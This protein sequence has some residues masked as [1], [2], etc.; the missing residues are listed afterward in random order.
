MRGDFSVFR[1]GLLEW[2]NREKRPLPWRTRPSLYGTVVSEFMLQ[3]TQ[4]ETVLPYYA[5]WLVTFPDFESLAKA[6]ETEVVKNW[7]GLGYYTRARNLHKLAKSICESGTPQSFD[8]WLNRPGIGPYSA[9]AISS[10]SQN[11]AE[12]VIDGNVIRVLCRIN[13]DDLPIRSST[14][15]RKRLLPLARD[16]IDPDHPG[17]FNE[18]IME[19]GATICRKSR[20]SCL[21]CP[22]REHCRASA[23]GNESSVPV[24]VRRATKRVSNSRLWLVRDDQLLLHFYPANAPRLA[25]LAELPEIDAAKGIAPVLKRTRGISTELITESI[26]QLDLNH[27]ESIRCQ[28]LG[29]SKW[30]PI[31]SLSSISLSGPHRRWIEALLRENLDSDIKPAGD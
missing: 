17:D 26:F 6:E 12:P 15:G 5:N 21:L 13:N 18:A 3:Q 24:I 8:E 4:V 16:L 20:P 14:D 31:H 10:I 30:V 27:P 29:D 9:A 7:Q 28:G 11:I 25:G 22:V 1:Q 23:C 2:F 19:L